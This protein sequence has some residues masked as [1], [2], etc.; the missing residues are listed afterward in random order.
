MTPLTT[1]ALVGRVAPGEPAVPAQRVETAVMQ[2]ATSQAKPMVS[3]LVTRGL[4]DTEAPEKM[5]LPRPLQE[6]SFAMAEVVVV[7][8]HHLTT[9]LR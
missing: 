8:S 4:V 2:L 6:R 1:V 7:V 3:A 5:D 9:P